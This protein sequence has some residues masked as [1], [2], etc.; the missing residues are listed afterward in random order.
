MVQR[1]TGADPLL[2]LKQLQR[3]SR[4]DFLKSDGAAVRLAVPPSGEVL[5]QVHGVVGVVL[6]LAV[7]HHAISLD[8]LAD[9]H[10]L[11]EVG[12]FCPDNLLDRL[13]DPRRRGLD[14]I[15]PH[16]D[17]P[18]ELVLVDEQHAPAALEL[19]RL[20]V[21]RGE[22][23]LQR[24]RRQLGARSLPDEVVEDE[25]RRVE[26]VAVGRGVGLLL[27]GRDVLLER[28]FEDAE[29]QRRPPRDTHQAHVEAQ[30]ALRE[31]HH[32]RD[33]E[34]RGD[35]DEIPELVLLVL[36]EV[37]RRV[38][39]HHLPHVVDEGDHSIPD[40]SA[41][42]HEALWRLLVLRLGH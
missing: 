23:A 34:R 10:E 32:V 31:H 26:D 33:V 28:V 22:H 1:C 25:Q 29:S 39:H 5:R 13:A 21:Q 16:V 20:H 24:R 18:V 8:E 14:E 35:V 9:V 17:R 3:E 40:L 12:D 41:P 7:R 11:S 30:H 15:V 2:N 42:D 38:R 27:H 19:D 36:L 4:A 37:R 6:G